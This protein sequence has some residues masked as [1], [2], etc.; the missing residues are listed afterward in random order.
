MKGKK[1]TQLLLLFLFPAVNQNY[2]DGCDSDGVR[3]LIARLPNEKQNIEEDF[4]LSRKF[5]VSICFVRTCQCYRLHVG[6]RGRSAKRI[7]LL[8][9]VDQQTGSTILRS[10]LAMGFV[11]S[12]CQS[13]PVIQ[14]RIYSLALLSSY[15]PT[16]HRHSRA[17]MARCC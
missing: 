5:Y 9:K 2:R 17:A 3:S 7:H 10:I 15:F 12:V 8:K 16:S 11:R 6:D 4:S 14:R 1:Q 13:R